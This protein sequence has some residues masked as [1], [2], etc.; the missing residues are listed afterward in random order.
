MSYYSYN[1]EIGSLTNR[2]IFL[3]IFVFAYKLFGTNVFEDIIFAI[4]GLLS[5]MLTKVVLNLIGI[6]RY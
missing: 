6:W 1:K 3:L 5:F 4:F 2:I